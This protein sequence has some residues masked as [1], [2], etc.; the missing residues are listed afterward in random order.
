MPLEINRIILLPTGTCF[1][2]SKE[3]LDTLISQGATPEFLL[4][5]LIVH[6][7]CRDDRNFKYAH[8]WIEHGKN[9]I[10]G[11][12]FAGV[13]PGKVRT[14]KAQTLNFL[15][16]AKKGEKFYMQMEKKD[17]Y[18]KFKVEELT[19][20]SFY[21]LRDNQI[22]TSGPWKRKYWKLCKDYSPDDKTIE[23][24]EKMGKTKVLRRRVERC[25]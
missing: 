10:T 7:I 14:E 18:V 8:S 2:D 16:G 23:I 5:H 24:C 9:A 15:E 6:G 12:I 1:D 17:F 22:N 13:Y 20:Y 11:G 3:Y 21:D 4:E 25:G 19:R